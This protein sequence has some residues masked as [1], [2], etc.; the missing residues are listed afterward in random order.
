M[1]KLALNMVP[2]Q[3]DMTVPRVDMTESL[4]GYGCNVIGR[5]NIIPLSLGRIRETYCNQLFRHVLI[6]YLTR[7][8]VL[9][10]DVNE[11]MLDNQG[12]S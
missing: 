9:T 6:M 3:L 11:L 2:P 8:R 12:A 1:I 5:W 4:C 10:P 7:S